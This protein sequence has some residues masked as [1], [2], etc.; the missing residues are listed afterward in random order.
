MNTLQASNRYPPLSIGI[1]WLTLLLL[2]GSY[3]LIELREFYPKGSDPRE[4][5]KTWH[6]MVG[7]VVLVLTIARLGLRHRVH[8]AAIE[9]L[10]PAWHQALATLGH[11]TL[12]VFLVVMPLLGWITL[13]LKGKPVPFFS[14]ELPA[15][16]GPDK[17]LAGDFEEIHETIGNIGYYLI[18]LHALAAL[19][20][21][22]FLHD[23]SLLRMLPAHQAARLAARSA[24]RSP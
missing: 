7:L 10:P 15:L 16:A 13:S 14:L 6:F 8:L 18:G 2:A 5:M 1:H 12:Y 24:R 20:H 21:H 4:L 11:I 9:P 19:Y 3:A 22:H 23:N 17:A